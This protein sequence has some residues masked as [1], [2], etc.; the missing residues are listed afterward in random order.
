M[1]KFLL[2]LFFIL[3]FQNPMYSQLRIGNIAH[4]YSI[5]AYDSASGQMGVAV[6]SHW[7]NVGSIV[8]WA[9]PGV[10]VVATQSLVD[11]TYGKLGLLLMREGKSA[12]Q[13]LE[14]LKK[15]DPNPAV[16]QV[17]MIDADGNVA[18]HTGQYC[19]GEA[20]HVKGTHFSCQA[21]LMLK[22]TVWQAMA[23]AYKESKGELADRLL[24]ALKAAQK[25]GGDIRGKQSAALIVVSIKKHHVYN[26][27]YIHN[28]RVDDSVQPLQ[29]LERLLT[30]S[31][32]YQNMNWGDYYLEKHETA[33]AMKSYRKAMELQPDNVEIKYWYAITLASIG[34]VEEALPFLKEVFRK[35]ANWKTVT[36]RLVQSKLFPDDPKL[37]QKVLNADKK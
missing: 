20:G 15:A 35:D 9:E 24:A 21:N 12:P 8:A 18:T 22:N 10:G 7:F 2:F 30:V 17:A 1:K 11:P 23:K 26:L 6:Q 33:N 36:R 4:T 19:I 31:K 32:A 13:V 27:D 5:V 34:E 3:L 37:L 16:R 28:I 25:E 14:A 29:E